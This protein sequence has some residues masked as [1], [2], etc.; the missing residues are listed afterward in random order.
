MDKKRNVQY[1]DSME[2]YTGL[3]LDDLLANY[4]DIPPL[5]E[6]IRIDIS[7]AILETV[8]AGLKSYGV[9][10]DKAFPYV[11]GNY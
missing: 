9:D 7:K 2:E 10:T 1:W 4:T 8:I 6:D 3:F 5:D 11:N